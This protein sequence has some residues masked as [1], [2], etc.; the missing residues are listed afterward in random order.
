M[1]GRKTVPVPV[2]RVGEVTL[3]EDEEAGWMQYGGRKPVC[4]GWNQFPFT[5]PLKSYLVW[6]RTIR[7]SYR[8][9][10]EK[11][12]TIMSAGGPSLIVGFFCRRLKLSMARF[13]TSAGSRLEA[14][15]RSELDRRSKNNTRHGQ[16]RPNGDVG[17]ANPGTSGMR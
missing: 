10:I 14:D 15:Y 8:Q 13:S 6:L 12:K 3:V 7:W 1:G 16:R 11:N 4:F 9:Q 5:E 2:S 17:A